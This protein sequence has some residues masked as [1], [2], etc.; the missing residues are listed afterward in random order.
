VIRTRNSHDSRLC[1]PY[2]GLFMTILNRTSLGSRLLPKE[3]RSKDRVV[4]HCRG[5]NIE[6][7]INDLYT[8]RVFHASRYR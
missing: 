1:E 7:T 8:D 6:C 5:P 4:L 3:V 2:D